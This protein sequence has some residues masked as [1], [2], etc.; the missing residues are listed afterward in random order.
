MMFST[1]P[2]IAALLSVCASHR[3]VALREGPS[4]VWPA[5]LRALRDSEQ[6]AE[7]I[8][9]FGT[10]LNKLWKLDPTALSR[11][12]D[13]GDIITGDL[14]VGDILS[15][16]D[17]VTPSTCLRL[18]Y[19]ALSAVDLQRLCKADDALNGD[20]DYLPMPVPITRMPFNDFTREIGVNPLW[21]R[22]YQKDEHLNSVIQKCGRRAVGMQKVG[23]QGLVNI[24]VEERQ[25]V[26][27]SAP[28]GST[29]SSMRSMASGPHGP[30]YMLLMST[31]AVAS[32]SSAPG[33]RAVVLAPMDW[34]ASLMP[35]NF[36]DVLVRVL[37]EAIRANLM[38]TGV[39]L[40]SDGNLSC[41]VLQY[42]AANV[43]AAGEKERLLP[44][45][46]V[47]ICSYEELD[48]ELGASKGGAADQSPAPGTA[49]P[50]HIAAKTIYTVGGVV[51][52]ITLLLAILQGGPQ[53]SG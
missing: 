52:A 46:R 23:L 38:R 7:P 22:G 27:F 53:V 30:L 4:D 3:L 34:Y 37:D 9:V 10:Q 15:A 5:K 25:W 40:Q 26:R 18:P 43:A 45:A 39:S 13:L 32:I 12:V 11:S 21:E 33:K 16:C 2:F 24:L 19:Q 50:F 28:L 48:Y 17:V 8:S 29:N 47:R 51:L 20:H 41:H 44:E 36:K 1:V 42:P 35:Q 14:G 31:D 6:Y 49:P